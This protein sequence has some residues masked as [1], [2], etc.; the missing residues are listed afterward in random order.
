M[1]VA[2]LDLVEGRRGD[3]AS[4]SVPGRED[5]ANAIRVAL[6]LG[7]TGADRCEVLVHCIADEPLER[8]PAAP[9]DVDGDVVR[10]PS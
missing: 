4:A 2:A 8:Q 6:E 1:C 10:L 9:A 7:A 3:H 5:I